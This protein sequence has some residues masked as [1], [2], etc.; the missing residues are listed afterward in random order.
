MRLHSPMLASQV[1]K[2]GVSRHKAVRF[3]YRVRAW[4]HAQVAAALREAEPLREELQKRGVL[5]VPLPIFDDSEAETAAAAEAAA[6][7][8][9]NRDVLPALTLEDQRWRAE[10]LRLADWKS[11]FEQQLSF[12]AKAKPENGCV[13][14]CCS[15]TQGNG[16]RRTLGEARFEGAPVRVG[17]GS[18]LLEAR[19]VHP[20][21]LGPQQ[22]CGV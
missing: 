16:S 3:G 17:S 18:R 20:G 8:T 2:A 6:A 12:S 13:L 7:G 1:C 19:P 15:G 9:A 11:W 14:L 10:P 21:D 4:G 22:F 5:V